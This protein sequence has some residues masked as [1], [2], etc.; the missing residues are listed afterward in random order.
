MFE[1]FH[2]VISAVAAAASVG[3][4]GHPSFAVWCVSHLSP[5]TGDPLVPMSA[6]TL[7]K[8]LRGAEPRL[9]KALLSFSELD[10]PAPWHIISPIDPA[11]SKVHIPC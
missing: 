6:R 1:L 4:F 3:A 7:P 11:L 9:R 8:P 2:V 10:C 5:G